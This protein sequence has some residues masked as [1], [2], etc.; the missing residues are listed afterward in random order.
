MRFGAASVLRRSRPFEG[1]IASIQQRALSKQTGQ[2]SEFSKH[3]DLF[4]ELDLD[5]VNLGVYNGKW[6]GEGPLVHSYNPA[7][8]NIIGSTRVVCPVSW[9]DYGRRLIGIHREL[10]KSSIKRW[11][12]L[13]KLSQLGEP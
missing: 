1:Q 3:A 7:T 11:K 4:R 13:R 5:E 12:L 6:S 10:S 2:V 8:N 9:G